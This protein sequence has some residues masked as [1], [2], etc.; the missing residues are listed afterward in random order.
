ML[1]VM[2]PYLMVVYLSKQL[3]THTHTQNE[4]KCIQ[5]IIGKF[6]AAD[7]IAMRQR[8]KFKFP[9]IFYSNK[10]LVNF[11]LRVRLKYFTQC[12]YLFISSI[13]SYIFSPLPSFIHEKCGWFDDLQLNKMSD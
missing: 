12:S 5:T 13:Y 8:F 9:F 10:M 3:Q 11:L 1:E 4:F 7:E 6:Y 2:C